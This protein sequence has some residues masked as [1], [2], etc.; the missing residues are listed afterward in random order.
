MH[1]VFLAAAGGAAKAM[2]PSHF[3][4]RSGALATLV[5][6]ALA[7]A[8]CQKSND[9]NG[10]GPAAA[11]SV[12]GKPAAGQPPAMPVTVITA[13]K[14]PV[15]VSIDVAGQAEG[16]RE[17]E[18]RT[19][20]AGI[21]ERKLFDEGQPVK[22][23]QP[24]YQIERAPFEIALAQARAA[25]AQ[26]QSRF[27]DARREAARLK[28]LADQRAISQREYDAA[29]TAA[30]NAEASR[31]AAQARVREA[32]LNLSYTLLKAPIDGVTGRSLKSEGSLVTPGTEGQL[33]SL[34]QADP[35]WVRFALTEQQ[36]RQLQSSADVD[37]LLVGP[38]GEPIG[39]QGSINFSAT[40]IDPRLGTIGLR[41]S[42]GNDR[43]TILPGQF[44][45]LRL[46]VNGRRAFL[47]P[48]QAVT[49][50]DR[51][52]AVWVV[53]DDGKA[54]AA[55]VTVA[56]WV[57]RDWVVEDGLKDGDR[58]IVD[59][60]MKLR[61]GAPVAPKSPGEAPPGAGAKAGGSPPKP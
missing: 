2:T 31:A 6:I 40:T 41:A 53:G 23:G 10:G 25:L 48:Q 38:A 11:G 44:V 24:L 8:G 3:P 32:D 49:Q 52:K 34:V 42:F 15:P 26:E 55:P 9:G 30:R 1:D 13:T 51:G 61:P 4:I 22:E 29:A 35:I 58:V 12:G 17:V 39:T 5:A 28:P 33:T 54:R 21:V 45:Q 37:V 20:V 56:E 18:V 43:R 50:S 36:L 57:G 47:V 27:E 59:N 60:L 7:L 46:R 14:Q 19:R 16:S